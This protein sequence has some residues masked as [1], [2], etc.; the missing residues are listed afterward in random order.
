[1][2]LIQQS[3]N[4]HGTI[5]WHEMLTSSY[6]IPLGG[7]QIRSS[8]LSCL[9]ISESVPQS[10]GQHRLDSGISSFHGYGASVHQQTMCHDTMDRGLTR[11]ESFLDLVRGAKRDNALSVL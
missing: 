8:Q 11:L 5:A 7:I 9:L 6:R 10:L 4:M 1:M 3:M 2:A